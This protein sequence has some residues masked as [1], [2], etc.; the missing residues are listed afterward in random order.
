MRYD[1][2]TQ[3]WELFASEIAVFNKVSGLLGAISK[4]T[5]DEEIKALAKGMIEKIEVLLGKIDTTEGKSEG[6][7]KDGSDGH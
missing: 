2:S 5:E 4:V 7:G 1:V 6:E 3:K